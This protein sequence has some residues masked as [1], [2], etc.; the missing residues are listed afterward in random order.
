[1]HPSTLEG[2]RGDD[3]DTEVS[4]ERL[5]EMFDQP[6]VPDPTDETIIHEAHIGEFSPLPSRRHS[7]HPPRLGSIG[8]RHTYVRPLQTEI[9][10]E[11]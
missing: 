2:E 4:I 3:R 7:L 10:I 9:F 8:L 6:S 5:Q 11:R 1:M